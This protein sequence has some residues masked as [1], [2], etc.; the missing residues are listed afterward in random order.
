MRWIVLAISRIL[1]AKFPV[2]QV[3]GPGR[4]AVARREQTRN[5][6]VPRRLSLM[7]EL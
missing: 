7:V 3:L 5:K 4:I 2:R 6:V 1:L